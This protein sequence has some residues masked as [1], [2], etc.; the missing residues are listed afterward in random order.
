M[1]KLLCM[2]ISLVL[3]LSLLTAC[4][5]KPQD[6][7]WNGLTIT[8]DSSFKT[9][10]IDSESASYACYYKMYVI[11]ITYETFDDLADVGYDPDMTLKAYGEISIEANEFDSTVQIEDGVTYYTYT[12][13]IDG[14]EFT[15]MATI[16]CMGNAFW[17][18]QFS[19]E[20]N[21]FEKAKP[22]FIEWA[23]TVAYTTETI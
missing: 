16:H 4:T 17:L 9:V 7:T 22:Q 23:K 3:V 12:A 1:K 19:T 10:E 11:M 5:A 6:F 18:V 2:A 13:D 15:Y 14:T 21:K 8:L 20:T